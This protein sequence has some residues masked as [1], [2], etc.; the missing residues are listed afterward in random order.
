MNVFPLSLEL[1]FV[2]YQFKI[3]SVS[4]YKCMTQFRDNFQVDIKKYFFRFH[5][6]FT[7]IKYISNKQVLR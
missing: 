3:L 2:G 5:Y 6:S 7:G 4:R 1:F